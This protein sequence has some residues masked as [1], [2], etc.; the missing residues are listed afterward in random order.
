MNASVEEVEKDTHGFLHRV[1][2]GETVVVFA[3]NQPVAEI[4]PLPKRMGKRPIGLARGHF[5][6]PDDFDDPLPEEV[7]QLFEGE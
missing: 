3:E 6:V 1:L 7:L 4:R 5:V 2:N